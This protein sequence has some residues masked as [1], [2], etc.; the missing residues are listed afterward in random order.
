MRAGQ[1]RAATYLGALHKM[2]GRALDSFEYIP[3]SIKYG[4]KKNYTIH[5]DSTIVVWS[6]QYAISKLS[7]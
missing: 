1:G 3:A 5:V 6:I 2:P 7:A 4:Y